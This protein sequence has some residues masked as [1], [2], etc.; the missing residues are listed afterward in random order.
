MKNIEVKFS[1]NNR[2]YSFNLDTIQRLVNDYERAVK[3]RH[4]KDT[5]PTVKAL[6]KLSN[7]YGVGVEDVPTLYTGMSQYLKE[8]EH[9]EQEQE[10]EAENKLYK[11][12]SEYVKSNNTLP[13]DNALSILFSESALVYNNKD[14]E[15][16]RE[17]YL[18]LAKSGK[19]ALVTTESVKNSVEAN[20][21]Y[22]E[23]L[24]SASVV[25]NSTST[26][27]K[28]RALVEASARK[29]EQ[30]KQLATLE[31]EREQL[32]QNNFQTMYVVKNGMNVFDKACRAW[33]SHIALYFQRKT[34][35]KVLS[36][37]WNVI[38]RYYENEI[39]SWNDAIKEAENSKDENALKSA[40]THYHETIHTYE[41]LTERKKS[42]SQ[43]ICKV[44]GKN[45]ADR[46]LE[47]AIK[48]GK[49]AEICIRSMFLEYGIDI[50]PTGKFMKRLLNNVSGTKNN[51]NIITFWRDN[52]ALV[53]NNRALEQV[54]YSLFDILF[55][56][57]I[58]RKCGIPSD[59]MIALD[60]IADKD[61]EYSFVDVPKNFDDLAMIFEQI[62]PALAEV[63]RKIECAKNALAKR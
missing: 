60:A 2:V 49:S 59:I 52:K 41:K 28:A 35:E 27:D 34:M 12:I 24:P 55:K 32:I 43:T 42:A 23:K 48:N 39:E 62:N 11:L 45:K 51:T 58:V 16:V 54:Y 56:A 40:T 9:K 29:A 31:Q 30:E 20:K 5:I 6:E 15:K 37:R 8:Q 57:G 4:G 1:A 47:L 25:E 14:A 7:V 33:T 50:E 26:T 53:E 44:W 46:A 61:K 19:Y 13:N 10:Q 36:M 18:K 63:D 38:K 3:A 22:F 21:S 17:T